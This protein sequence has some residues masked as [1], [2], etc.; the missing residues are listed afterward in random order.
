MIT[1]RQQLDC[2]AFNLRKQPSFLVI[3]PFARS[4]TLVS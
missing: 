2:G 4:E 1:K 3:S